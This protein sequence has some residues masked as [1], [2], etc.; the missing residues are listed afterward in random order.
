[1]SACNVIMLK[2]VFSSDA[3]GCFE[4]QRSQDQ[5]LM[6]ECMALLQNMTLTNKII[7]RGLVTIR[8]LM[9]S[10]RESL[11]SYSTLDPQEM[12]RLLVEVEGRLPTNVLV[13]EVNDMGF[14][15]SIFDMFDADYQQ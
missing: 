2:T 1:M 9:N 3:L 4:L 12:H 13:R 6:E 14:L 7:E 5:T 11:P 8:R 10:Q 15:E